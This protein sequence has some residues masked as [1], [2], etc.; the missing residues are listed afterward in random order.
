MAEFIR[1]VKLITPP[2]EKKR[3]A[4][5]GKDKD[6]QGQGGEEDNTE[7]AAEV[8]ADKEPEPRGPVKQKSTAIKKRKAV[9]EK[10]KDG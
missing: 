7:V 4:V 1:A 3:N 5:G 9:G 6:N 8:A 2:K 10:D